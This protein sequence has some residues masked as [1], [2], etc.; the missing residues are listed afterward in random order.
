MNV[1]LSQP[2]LIPIITLLVNAV[3]G[4]IIL[5]LMLK[6][7]RSR[8]ANREDHLADA[9]IHIEVIQSLNVR[10]TSLI[11]EKKT[12]DTR[13]EELLT[14]YTGLIDSGQIRRK[15]DLDSIY[16]LEI[17]IAEAKAERLNALRKIETLYRN[18]ELLYEIV[19][20]LRGDPALRNDPDRFTQHMERVMRRMMESEGLRQGALPSTKEI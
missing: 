15:E 14:K 1:F 19:E 7:E 20:R 16:K 17:E 11:E 9:K 5:S 4:P 6:G 18:L 13:Y 3:L 10:V 2:W 8:A 12:S